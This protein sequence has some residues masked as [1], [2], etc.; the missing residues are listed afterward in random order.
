MCLSSDHVQHYNST[1]LLHWVWSAV[2]IAVCERYAVLFRKH[3]SR[4][5]FG[6]GRAILEWVGL[7]PEVVNHCYGSPTLDEEAAIQKGMLKWRET[8]GDVPLDVASPT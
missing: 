2:S 4:N 8:H 7:D 6:K 5:A 1:E 3:I